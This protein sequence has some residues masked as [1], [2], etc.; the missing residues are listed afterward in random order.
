MIP[1]PAAHGAPRPCRGRGTILPPPP[2]PSGVVVDGVSQ[3]LPQAISTR[4]RRRSSRGRAPRVAPPQGPRALVSFIPPPSPAPPAPAPCALALAPAPAHLRRGSFSLSMLDRACSPAAPPPP[5]LL[6]PPAP[7]SRVGSA[8]LSMLGREWDRVSSLSARAEAASAAAA[9]LDR[10]GHVSRSRLL[11]ANAASISS[12]LAV[13]CPDASLFRGSVPMRVSGVRSLVR[14]SSR[15]SAP[16]SG[17]AYESS[18]EV[19]FDLNPDFAPLLE[20]LPDDYLV[21]IGSLPT[22]LQVE[23]GP[24]MVAA[25][26]LISLMNDAQVRRVCGMPHS[27][28]VECGR[29]RAISQLVATL[30][31]KWSAGYMIQLANVW[32][33]AMK[34]SRSS[35]RYMHDGSFSGSFTQAY[36]A[37]VDARARVRWLARHPDPSQAPV[38]AAKGATARGGAGSKLRTLA[39]ALCFPIDVASLGAREA[40]KRKKRVGQRKR[41]ATERVQLKLERMAALAPSWCVRVRAA[42]FAAMGL[43]SLRHQSA[44]R[45]TIRRAPPSTLPSLPSSTLSSYREYVTASG[46]TVHGLV[47]VDPKAAVDDGIPSV[48]SARGISGSR[49]WLDVLLEVQRVSTTQCLVYDTAL[50]DGSPVGDPFLATSLLDAPSSRARSA[51]ALRAILLSDVCEPSFTP[52]MIVG[53]APHSLKHFLPTISRNSLDPTHVTNEIGKWSGSSS[54]TEALPAAGEAPLPRSDSSMHREHITDVYSHEA[55]GEGGSV[56]VVMEL[57]ISRA[58]R[59]IASLSS[60]D[61]LPASGGFGYYASTL[62]RSR[63]LP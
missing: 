13:L 44:C 31:R 4:S 35:G 8:S 14:R 38:G 49:A 56:A 18:F 34:F 32:V 61:A 39:T 62:E 19:P 21:H 54:Q 47:L 63:C 1:L 5:A 28:F 6:C 42:G 2:P 15:A 27:E 48:T 33:D 22:Q 57:Q 58:R 46:G 16:R 11:L 10:M 50:E 24:K 45:F 53:L 40:T 7:P 25:R 37:R 30:C 3:P 59:R 41:S 23:E 36:M 12:E 55:L 60:V 52:E 20:G 26:R 43:N 17:S 9:E 29:D 51:E